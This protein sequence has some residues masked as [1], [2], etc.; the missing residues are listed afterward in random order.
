MYTRNSSDVF[1]QHALEAKLPPLDNECG[2]CLTELGEKRAVTVLPCRHVYHSCCL[3]GM[4]EDYSTPK[5][6][7]EQCA[8]CRKPH[9]NQYWLLQ[10]VSDYKTIEPQFCTN[11]GCDWGGKVNN[12]VP[13]CPYPKSRLVE[14]K[15]GC[16]L[17]ANSGV[18]TNWLQSSHL[19]S[20]VE[21]EDATYSARNNH[22]QLTTHITDSRGYR[23]THNFTYSQKLFDMCSNKEECF[24]KLKMHLRQGMAMVLFKF[25]Y[26]NVF[27][28]NTHTHIVSYDT[29]KD[30]LTLSSMG[31]TKN[32]TLSMFINTD[33]KC[34][35]FNALKKAMEVVG[36]VYEELFKCQFLPKEVM[37]QACNM[38]GSGVRGGLGLGL[39]LGLGQGLGQGLNLNPGLIPSQGGSIR[40]LDGLQQAFGSHCSDTSGADETVQTD[41]AT[42]EGTLS[43]DI[44]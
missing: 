11:A 31:K 40:R 9:K 6:M 26:P 29:D 19:Q 41:P 36:M 44:P 33:K 5:F 2:V 8:V 22:I 13:D 10:S 14:C 25:Q 15:P 32:L 27:A 42:P 18:L 7:P 34:L 20:N 23:S 17:E 38:H 39:G 24:D 3:Q 37:G 4:S 12:F 30:T 16:F 35:D 1:S 28:P 43:L 21:L